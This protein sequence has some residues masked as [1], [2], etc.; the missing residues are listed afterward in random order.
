[1]LNEIGKLG[2]KSYRRDRD[3]VNQMVHTLHLGKIKL[4]FIKRVICI[5]LGVMAYQDK[6][7]LTDRQKHKNLKIGEQEITFAE[8]ID[9]LINNTGTCF[10]ERGECHTKREGD[11]QQWI[12][13]I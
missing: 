11:I 6:Y 13:V 8:Q 1:M 7:K 5:L 2:V 4:S 12:M 10:R 9:D 3:C